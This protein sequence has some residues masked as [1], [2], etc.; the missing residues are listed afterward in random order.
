[1]TANEAITYAFGKFTM[2]LSYWRI[3]YSAVKWP[4]SALS[5]NINIHNVKWE[6][7]SIWLLVI[8]GWFRR[9][10]TLLY[11]TI[12]IL[13]RRET[14][15]IHCLFSW[16]PIPL[17]WVIQLYLTHIHNKNLV[18]CFLKFTVSIGTLCSI[19][20]CL[21]CCISVLL[22]TNSSAPSPPYIFMFLQLLSTHGSSSVSWLLS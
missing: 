21:Y 9:R 18:F 7:D 22:Y 12:H 11:Y 13:W 17:L 14:C 1:M 19:L 3:N 20:V 8:W 16:Q 5:V 10:H 6:I 2:T 4:W 15:T